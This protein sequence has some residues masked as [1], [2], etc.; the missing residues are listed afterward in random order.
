MLNLETTSS[1]AELTGIPVA[2]NKPVVGSNAFS[3]A[4]G[5]HQHGVLKERSTY[6]ILSAADVGAG[7]TQIV[8]TAR[9]GRHA[10]THRLELIG[11]RV[12]ESQ[13]PQVWSRFLEVADSTKEVGDEALL[14]IIGEV[15][16]DGPATARVAS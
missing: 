14:R 11:I 2:P 6:E 1:V 12:P 3:H 7:A 15:G 16:T 13:M 8:L 9:S 5:V 10:L 4:S